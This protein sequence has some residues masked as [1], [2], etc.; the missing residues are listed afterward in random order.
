MTLAALDHCVAPLHLEFEGR[1]AWCH[2]DCAFPGRSRQ[3]AVVRQLQELIAHAKAA[4]GQLNYSTPGP[5]TLPHLATEL[6]KL[7]TGIDMVHIPYSGAA[8]PRRRC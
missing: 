2:R 5:G 8:P 4:P 1:L 7:R 3:F 6:L